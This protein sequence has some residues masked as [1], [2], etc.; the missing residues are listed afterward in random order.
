MLTL[1]GEMQK[2]PSFLSR[3]M[4]N[5]VPME[6]VAGSAG[7]TTTVMR[8]SART[9]IV[10]HLICSDQRRPSAQSGTQR[11]AKDTY[12]NLDELADAER[13]TKDRQRKGRGMKAVLGRT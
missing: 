9:R 8:S 11:D 1:L 2:M 6:S 4:A 10:C 3:S 7:G 13:R 12:S 5:V